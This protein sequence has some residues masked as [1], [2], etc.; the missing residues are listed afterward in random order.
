MNT[1]LFNRLQ[2]LTPEGLS[3]LDDEDLATLDRLLKEERYDKLDARCSLAEVDEKG[4]AKTTSGPLFWGQ[5]LTKTFDDHALAKSTPSKAPFPRKSY[6]QVL[7]GELLQPVIHPSVDCYTTLVCKS[8]EMV[9]S[10]TICLY[11]AW[12]CQW[13]PGTLAV[14]QTLKETKAEALIRYIA[15]LAENQEAFLKE[16]HPLVRS[17]ALEIEWRNGSRVFGIP[18]GENQIRMFHPFAVCFDEMAFMEDA[19]ACYD[20]VKPVAKQI[21][22]VSSAFPGWMGDMCSI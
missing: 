18:G 10:W 9:S 5:T 15:I 7:M 3:R 22:G 16:R 4:W 11:L 12:L 17:V 6:F 13:R 19:Q 1:Q 20:P 14:V 21:V 2:K 8:R